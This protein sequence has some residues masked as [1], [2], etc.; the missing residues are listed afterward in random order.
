MSYLR[1]D[2]VSKKF[3]ER[4]ILDNV[5]FE[6]RRGECLVV[7]GPSGVGKTTLLRV[8][9]GILDAVLMW[10]RTK[11][12]IVEK[13]GQEPPKGSASYAIMRSFQMRISRVPRPQVAR[14]DKDWK[15]AR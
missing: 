1:L 5:S 3:G 10:R 4:A 12:A 7:F 6:L 13:F 2:G 8:I 9:A 11:K 15:N 14:G